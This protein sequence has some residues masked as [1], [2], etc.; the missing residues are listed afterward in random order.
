[1]T[2]AAEVPGCSCA[3]VSAA[4]ESRGKAERHVKVLAT[5]QTS[6]LLPNLNHQYHL[7]FSTGYVPIAY[8]LSVAC[9]HCITPMA[10]CSSCFHYVSYVCSYGHTIKQAAVRESTLDLAPP[11][12]GGRPPVP[13]PSTRV[14]RVRPRQWE[15]QRT[16]ARTAADGGLRLHQRDMYILLQL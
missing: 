9:I 7:P 5:S 11:R 6:S 3:E 12:R 4:K 14:L 2:V 1:M 8:L 10:C 13:L 15:R 16:I